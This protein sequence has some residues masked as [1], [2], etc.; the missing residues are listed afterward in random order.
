[1]REHDEACSGQADCNETLLYTGEFGA[2]RQKPSRLGL[3]D[4]AEDWRLPKDGADAEDVCDDAR[5]DEQHGQEVVGEN[6]WIEIRQHRGLP[7]CS[8]GDRG[9]H[10]SR[11]R[12]ER[13]LLLIQDNGD[14][15]DQ[16]EADDDRGQLRRQAGEV[17]CSA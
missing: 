13:L 4:V 3:V 17:S 2:D 7:L 1:M 14:A 15:A 6:E 16:N 8:S 11:V 10:D 9:Q 12:R 5:E